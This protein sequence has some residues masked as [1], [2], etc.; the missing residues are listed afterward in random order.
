M[1]AAGS[2]QVYRVRDMGIPV[3]SWGIGTAP[4]AFGNSPR[5]FVDYRLPYSSAY[6]VV[7]Y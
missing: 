3:V 5:E 4:R 1:S 2:A 6:N 7:E